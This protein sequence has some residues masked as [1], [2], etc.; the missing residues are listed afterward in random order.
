[1]RGTRRG[2]LC[3]R[4]SLTARLWSVKKTRA[5]LSGDAARVASDHFRR[6]GIRGKGK[7]KVHPRTGHEVPEGE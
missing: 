2:I 3:L 6:V 7:G 1:M 5:W 4:K